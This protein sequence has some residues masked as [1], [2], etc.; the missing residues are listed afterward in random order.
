MGRVFVKSDVYYEWQ[1][2]YLNH[3]VYN[4]APNL[5]VVKIIPLIISCLHNSFCLQ[6]DEWSHP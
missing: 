5:K 6:F 3:V 4:D 1:P 2:M